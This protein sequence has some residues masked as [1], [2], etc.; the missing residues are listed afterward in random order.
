MRIHSMLLSTVS[1]LVLCTVATAQRSGTIGSYHFSIPAE[2]LGDA[3]NELAQQSGLQVLFPSQL[4]A[5]FSGPEVKGSLTAENALNRLLAHTGLRFEFVNS[6]TITIIGADQAAPTPSR[7]TVSRDGAN[8]VAQTA[9]GSGNLS[10]H[11]DQSGNNVM[12][13]RSLLARLLGAF[14]IC[15]SA[16]HAS[17]A[18][19]QDAA[20]AVPASLEEVVITAQKRTEKLEDVPV[21]ASVVSGDSVTQ[22]NAGD[23][24]DLNR[25]VPSV[26]L[27]GTINGRVPLGIRGISSVSS[28]QAVG[29]SSGVALMIDGVPVPSDSRAA[30]ALEDVQ[31]IEVLKGHRRPSAAAR[32]RPVSSISSRVSRAIHSRAVSRR[33]P[34]MTMSTGR[35]VTSPGPSPIASNTVCPPT[36]RRVNSR[37]SIRSWIAGPPNAF[38]VCAANCYSSRMTIWISS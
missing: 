26:E 29:V 10:Q 12:P 31:N 11:L 34:P 15:G 16:G 17:S 30:N 24:S 35:T 5:Q 1:A 37:F 27:N 32:P 8:P 28:E 38:L 20:Q 22:L 4:V 25:L 18:C 36:A 33:K 3:L 7:P 19:A 2:P 14:V 6:H 9:G 13:H 23:I 21:A